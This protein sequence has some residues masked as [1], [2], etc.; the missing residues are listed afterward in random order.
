MMRKLFSFFVVLFMLSLST[1]TQAQSKAGAEYFA[2]SWTILIK[3]TPNGDVKLVLALDKKTDSLTG[4]VQ[5]TTGTEVSKI[6]SIELKDN[7]VTVY[8]STQGY[9]V[10]VNLVKK[11]DDHANGT[12]MNMFEVEGVRK[13]EAKK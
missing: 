13:K 11:D 8:F 6:S 5:D 9:D 12:L 4:I 2:G 1:N 3:G 7:E 10:N